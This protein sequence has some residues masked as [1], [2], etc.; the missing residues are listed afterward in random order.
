VALKFLDELKSTLPG[1]DYRMQRSI[2]GFP[3]G[4]VWMTPE[5]KKNICRYGQVLFLDGQKRQYNK[6]NWPYIGPALKDNEMK[7]CLGA[8]S[9]VVEE[10]LKSYKWVLES[11]CEMEPLFDLSSIKIIF[12]DQL[13]THGL[14]VSL[15]IRDT[16]LLRPDFYHL[17]NEVWPKSENFGQVLY[18]RIKNFMETMLKST[19]ETEYTNA[20]E[21][22][23]AVVRYEPSK[24]SYL[25][26][27][28]NDHE[29]YGGFFLLHT[30]GNLGLLGSCPAEQNHSSIVAHLG[31]GASWEIAAHIQHLMNRQKELTKQRTEKENS[32]FCSTLHYKSSKRGQE[33]KDEE[34]AKKTLSNYA[35]Q[36]LFIRKSFQGARKLRHKYDAEGNCF[37][38]PA[39]LGVKDIY[40]LEHSRDNFESEEHINPE[41]VI[42]GNGL[43]RIPVGGRCPCT[44]RI[45]FMF[46]CSHEYH[47]DGEF[48]KELYNGFQWFTRRVYNEWSTIQIDESNVGGDGESELYEDDAAAATG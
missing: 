15:G 25:E 26:S 28:Y 44:D 43:Y 38:W 32:H 23:L 12:G 47:R 13:I 19:T 39:K 10:S 48:K 36:K 17:T 9:I 11:M 20:Y 27:I 2:D 18:P 30:S 24:R 7:V 29:Y 14:L 35:F 33:R 40:G 34:A 45:S 3:I 31:E 4:I 41:L 46:Q 42:C 1:F 37:I 8:E 6:M 21:A 16:C 5:M 22:A